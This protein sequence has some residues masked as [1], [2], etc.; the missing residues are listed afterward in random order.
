MIGGH[1]VG[2]GDIGFGDFGCKFYDMETGDWVLN[3]CS[4]FRQLC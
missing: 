2:Q 3:N 4:N 1:D